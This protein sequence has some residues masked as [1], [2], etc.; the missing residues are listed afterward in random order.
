[1]RAR[2]DSIDR[3]APSLNPDEVVSKVV[4]LLLDS[5]LTRFADSDDTDHSGYPDSDPQNSQ[6]ASHLVSEQRHQCGSKE[7]SVVHNLYSFLSWEYPKGS[8]PQFP[9]LPLFQ[10]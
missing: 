10:S 7:S 2:A 6:D 4:Q 9:H 3:T 5:R 8:T 1:M